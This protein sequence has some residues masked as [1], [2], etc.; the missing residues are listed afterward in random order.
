MLVFDNFNIIKVTFITLNY[1][2]LKLELFFIAL[3]KQ[4]KY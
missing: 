4:K 2:A 3:L 1:L